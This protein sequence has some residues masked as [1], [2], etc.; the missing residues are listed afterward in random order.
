MLDF[1][2]LPFPQKADVQIFNRP[3]PNDDLQ[4]ETWRKP[5]GVSMVQIFAFAGGG[6]GGGGFTGI[7]GSARGGGGG[8]ASNACTRVLGPEIFFPDRLYLKIGRGGLGGAAGAAGGAGVGTWVATHPDVTSATNNFL[9]CVANASSG[10]GAGTASA[11]GAG[12]TGGISSSGSDMSL[13]GSCV[14]NSIDGQ[15]GVSGGDDLGA[16]GTAITIPTTSVPCQGGSGG[17]GTTSADFAGGACTAL[18]GG[19][20]VNYLDDNRPATPASGSNNGSG[21]PQ[22]WKPFFSF[23]GLGGSSSNTGVGGNGGNGAHG[24]GGGGGGGGT[25][26]GSGGDGGSGL[27]IIVSW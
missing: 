15:S 3:M 2:H 19:S 25:T 22:L 26:G 24:A 10:G 4:W 14:F 20:G 23:G 16:N 27:V 11:G 21:G 6:G 1:G 7:A 9:R 12:G 8:G 18:A 17:G 13:A 5:R